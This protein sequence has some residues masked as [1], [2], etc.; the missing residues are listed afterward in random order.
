MASTASAVT[1]EERAVAA[2]PA[3]VAIMP[4][5][6]Q[7]LANPSV[8]GLVPLNDFATDEREAAGLIRRLV[9]D[10]SNAGSGAL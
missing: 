5:S 9:C 4:N 10:C 1:N 3:V 8:T 6:A 2:A 7:L